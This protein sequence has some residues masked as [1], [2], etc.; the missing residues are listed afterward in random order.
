MKND[1]AYISYCNKVKECEKKAKEVYS[2]LDDI[3]GFTPEM[4]ELDKVGLAMRAFAKK[5]I[6]A[7]EYNL[8][9]EYITKGYVDSCILSGEVQPSP[10]IFCLIDT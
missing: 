8:V 1:A 6:S 7:K 9:S 2:I 3:Y 10:L 5:I 4:T